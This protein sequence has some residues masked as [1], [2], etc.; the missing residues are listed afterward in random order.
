MMA[1]SSVEEV[2]NAELRPQEAP[3][4]KGE[5]IL[6]ACTYMLAGSLSTAPFLEQVLL[7]PTRP[8]C[9]RPVVGVLDFAIQLFN[10]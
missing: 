6:M 2:R 7:I 10:V 8:A 9:S 4:T 5:I 1:S 3:S